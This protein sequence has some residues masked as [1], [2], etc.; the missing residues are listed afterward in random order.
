[1]KRGGQLRTGDKP[2]LVQAST[3]P[4][5]PRALPAS[6]TFPGR[7][8]SGAA[9]T[10]RLAGAVAAATA[11]A[12]TRLPLAPCTTW[13]T[14][15]PA[16]P[17]ILSSA[18]PS[19]AAPA[20]VATSASI[21]PTWL[22]PSACTP[23]ASSGWPSALWPRTACPTR[24]P[25]GTCGATT[26][27]SSPTPPSRTGSRPRGKKLRAAMPDAYLDQALADFSGYLAIDEVYD[28]PFCILSAVD[29][30]RYDRLASR[31]LDHDPTRQDVRDFLHGFKGQ[32]DKRGLKVRGVTTDGSSLYPEVLKELWPE[33]RHQL[34]QFH[35]LKEIVKA[36]LH[37]LAV[38]RKELAARAPRLP[39]GRPGK[40]RQAQ[41]R[42]AKRQKQRVAELFEHRHLFVRRQLSKAQRQQ[43]QRLT[44]GLPQLR[45]LREIMD[46]G[47]RRFDRRCKTRTAVRKLARLRR[48]VRRFKALGQALKKLTSPNLEKALEF[49]DDKLLGSTSNAVERSNR[50]F[51]KAQSSIYSARTKE[52][53]E[54]RLALDLHREQ[55]A[56]N[57]AC[58]LRAL[59]HTRSDR[60]PAHP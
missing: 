55:R 29:N 52:H 42:K 58:C 50:R 21:W 20:A 9:A 18:T 32:L 30:R 24:P 46:E 4:T 38:L 5:S 13:A 36:V 53:L 57:R 3:S 23:A 39:R 17:S 8:S 34:C 1:M 15:A 41:A 28:G 14:P 37:A 48:R 45:R 49:L 60:E 59:H 6:R 51:R 56:G 54:Q 27:S 43:L 10:T 16:A 12:A 7:V 11:P 26:G 44:R 22:C 2:C 35:V 40:G 19:I 31:V 47:Y 25:A 33:A